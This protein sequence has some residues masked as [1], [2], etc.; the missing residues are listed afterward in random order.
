MKKKSFIRMKFKKLIKV[1]LERFIKHEYITSFS[2][3]MYNC[4]DKKKN[5]SIGKSWETTRNLHKKIDTS[6]F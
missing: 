2:G 5:S 1:I 3:T 6:I 4:T